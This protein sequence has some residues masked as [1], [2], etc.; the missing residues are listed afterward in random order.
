[1][2]KSLI[3]IALLAVCAPMF[4]GQAGQSPAPAKKNSKPK[5]AKKPGKKKGATTPVQK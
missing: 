2:K 3:A 5:K 4:A 1:M